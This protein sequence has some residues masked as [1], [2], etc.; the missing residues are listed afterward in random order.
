MKRLP[1]ATYLR[2]CFDYD[3]LSGELRWRQRPW[4]HFEHIKGRGRTMWNS[5]FPGKI[6]GSIDTH[7]ARQVEINAETHLVHR[8]IWKWMTGED[9]PDEVDHKNRTNND[10]RWNNLRIAN[11]IQQGWNKAARKDSVSGR[12]G[13][14]FRNGRWGV[15]VRIDGKVRRLG[16]YDTLEEAAAVHDAAIRSVH[17]E[18]FPI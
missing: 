18:F 1:S 16:N 5:R 4:A 2:E 6:A 13:V 10:N 8:V 11:R 17:G 9:P 7:G 12:R 15:R 14:Q 3:P